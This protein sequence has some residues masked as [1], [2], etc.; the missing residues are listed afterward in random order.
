ML[1]IEAGTPFREL[2]DIYGA[3]KLTEIH[4]QREDWQKQASR[5]LAEGKTAHAL[6]AYKDK[7]ALTQTG[8]ASEAMEALV[9]QYAMDH[10]AR[11]PSATRLA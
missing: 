7:R 10:V 9:E 8:D 2:V 11:S 5:D 3:A 1:P 4:R 6:K